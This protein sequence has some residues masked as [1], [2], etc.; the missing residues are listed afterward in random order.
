MTVFIMRH[1]ESLATLDPTLFGRTD[2]VTIPVSEWGHEQAVDS[3]RALR[4]YY[5]NNPE[6]AGRKLRVYFSPHTRI[7]QSK[8]AFLEGFQGAVPIVSETVEPLIREREH[9]DFNGLDE[10]QQ[11]ALNP[12]IFNKLHH[13]DSHERYTTRMPNGESMQDLDN[14]MRA[15]IEKLHAQASPDED[16]LVVTH[17]GNCR[18]LE[19]R[20]VH[21][22]ANWIEPDFTVPG[23]GDILKIETDF[24]EPGVSETLH[25]G[26][27]RPPHLPKDYKTAAHGAEQNSQAR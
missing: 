11:E 18:A 1:G 2:P 4:E 15:F 21:Y 9:G 8:D 3:G 22:N 6:T 14:R 12:E 16:V 7:V 10:A 5:E 13:G 17:G 20:L 23:T 24:S 27:K 19:D 25:E 26:R